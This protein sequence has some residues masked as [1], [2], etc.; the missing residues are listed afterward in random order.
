MATAATSSGNVVDSELLTGQQ[1]QEKNRIIA[2][3][4][5]KQIQ[6][7]EMTASAK[8]IF[9]TLFDKAICIN[10]KERDDRMENAQKEF[11]KVGLGQMVEFL[12]VD[13]HPRGGS[14]GCF[15][16][17][18]RAVREAQATSLQS[19]WDPQLSPHQIQFIWP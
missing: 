4:T 17:H 7:T 12:R 1:L 15:D 14:Y 8:E 18:R 10:L 3:H 2:F 5:I 11:D 9:P 13:R 6:E 16:S 19:F